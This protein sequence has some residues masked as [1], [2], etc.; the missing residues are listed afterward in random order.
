MDQV[1]RAS[2]PAARQRVTPVPAGQTA[3]ADHAGR[4]ISIRTAARCAYGAGIGGMVVSLLFIGFYTL[5]IRHPDD[6][7]LG[8]AS[9]VAGV[10]IGLL[11]PA[12]LALNAYLPARRSTRIIQAAG[13]AAMATDAAAGPLLVAGLLDFNIAT[14]I[15]AVSILLIF[16]WVTLVSRM[17]AGTGTFRPRVTRF[18]QRLGQAA[19]VALALIAVGLPLPWMSLPQLILAGTGA[20]IGAITWLILP[21]W[22]LFLGQNLTRAALRPQAAF[23]PG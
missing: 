7:P 13:I 18:G 4:G 9:D 21:A 10:T 2:G 16:G 15:S 17:L 1:G 14:P 5:E 8:T 19:L 12:A 20:G 11:I 6:A 22:Y 3:Q 23:P